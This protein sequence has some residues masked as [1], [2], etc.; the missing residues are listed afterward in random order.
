M[1]KLLLPYYY[2]RQEFTVFNDILFNRVD[3][4]IETHF[5]FSVESEMSN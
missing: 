1:F 2:Y 5:H 4:V 3:N